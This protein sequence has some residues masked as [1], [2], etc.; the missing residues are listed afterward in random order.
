MESNLP[1]DERVD[2]PG[3]ADESTDGILSIITQLPAVLILPYDESGREIFRF[4]SLNIISS[5]EPPDTDLHI[6]PTAQ[7]SGNRYIMALFFMA[8]QVHGRC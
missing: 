1:F 2:T 4:P 8:F 5:K 6:R 3:F 7:L